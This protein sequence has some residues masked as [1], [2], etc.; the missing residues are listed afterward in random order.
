M[1]LI[2]GMRALG[3]DVAVT[4]DP[5]LSLQAGM[6][7]A[8]VPGAVYDVLRSTA[9][10]GIRSF[11]SNS[12]AA[13]RTKQFSA[14]I[15]SGGGRPFSGAPHLLEYYQECPQP[16][17]AGPGTLLIPVGRNQ[18][19]PAVVWIPRGGSCQRVLSILNGGKAAGS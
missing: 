9:Q 18:P 5:S 14:I 19:A 12:A 6:A 8:A 7:P 2:A 10:S 4:S 11:T 1:R 17:P 15:S 3:G 16:L 13:V